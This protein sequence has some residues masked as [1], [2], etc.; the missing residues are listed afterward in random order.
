MQ[1][2]A[3][4]DRDAQADEQHQGQSLC[5]GTGAASALER[6]KSLDQ[7]RIK[8]QPAQPHPGNRVQSE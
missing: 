7:E 1:S 2:S 8:Q 3:D 6:L 4:R 5:G